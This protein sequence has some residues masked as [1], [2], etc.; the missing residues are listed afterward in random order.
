MDVPPPP[1]GL[2][3]TL[4]PDGRVEV[5][6]VAD[7][8]ADRLVSFAEVGIACGDDKYAVK[9][10]DIP[11][12]GRRSRTAALPRGDDCRDYRVT[13]DKARW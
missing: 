10:T 5:E 1:R 2:L 7:N 11:A 4:F 9:P 6:A 3:P 8:R 13:L 12:G